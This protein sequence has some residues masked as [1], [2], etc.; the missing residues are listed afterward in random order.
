MVGFSPS[1]VG[2]WL[3]AFGSQK[4]SNPNRTICHLNE[5]LACSNKTAPWKKSFCIKTKTVLTGWVTDKAHTGALVG[6]MARRGSSTG[7]S[8]ITNTLG[9]GYERPGS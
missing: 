3:Q 4:K 7:G 2:G 6:L 8:F 1:I 5:W 9:I